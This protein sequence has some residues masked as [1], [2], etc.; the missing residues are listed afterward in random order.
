MLRKL[1]VLFFNKKLFEMNFQK[2]FCTTLFFLCNLIVFAQNQDDRYNDGS[3]YDEDDY[4]YSDN[5]QVQQLYRENQ[6]MK[7][8]MVEQQM[9][10]QL[11]E[12]RKAMM[13]DPTRAEMGPASRIYK[14][15][16]EYRGAHETSDAVKLDQQ[17][18]YN[19]AAVG[20]STATIGS[21]N[22][23]S[24]AELDKSWLG[25]QYDNLVENKEVAIIIGIAV[26]FII[27]AIPRTKT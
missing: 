6:A 8:E 24:L 16:A 11:E 15:R 4:Y 26:L 9:I 2:I 22:D 17:K 23:I 27:I 7:Q 13:A 5:E 1:L 21:D 19:R 3:Y 14:E 18:A 10:Q 25:K 12:E 20:A